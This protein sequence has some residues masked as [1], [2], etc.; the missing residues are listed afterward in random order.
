MQMEMMTL[1]MEKQEQGLNREST[2]ITNDKTLLSVLGHLLVPR[3]YLAYGMVITL[4]LI[5]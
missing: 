4:I 5:P 1:E 3:S 2:V